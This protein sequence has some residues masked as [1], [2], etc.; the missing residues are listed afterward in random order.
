V[1]VPW[2]KFD[3]EQVAFIGDPTVTIQK[4][5]VISINGAAYRALREPRFVELYYERSK[6]LVGI[7][8]ADPDSKAAYK[9]RPL[10]N[11]A[12]TWLISG[13]SFMKYYDI[14]TSIGRR[15]L[16]QIDPSGMLVFDLREPA[17][18]VTGNR[19]NNRQERSPAYR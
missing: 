5:G 2:E 10:K 7:A 8:N 9:V 17:A 14:D 15:W 13:T 6:R 1:I 16:G 3:R 12:S 18:T 19:S 11:S 4:G